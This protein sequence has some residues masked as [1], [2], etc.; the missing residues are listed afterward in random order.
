MLILCGFVALSALGC[1]DIDP[2]N[3]PIPNNDP[4]DPLDAGTPAASDPCKGAQICRLDESP[5]K[6]GTRVPFKTN[7]DFLMVRKGG[8]WRSIFI[9]G[10]NLGVGVPGT[11]AGHLAATREQYA[12]W[13][14][15][16]TKNG[17]NALRIYTL[18]Y[19]RF[20][21]ELAK[22]NK[23]HADNPIYLLQ[24]IWLDEQFKGL[25]LLTEDF[26]FNIR[27][28]V[29]CTRG[30][31]HINHRYGRAYGTFET[32]VSQWILGWVIGREV[33]PEEIE[34]TNEH[35]NDRTSFA[36]KHI[37]VTDAQPS[38][39]W[40]GERVDYLIEYELEGY[41]QTRPI[42]VSS[43]PTLD[44]LDHTTEGS[45]YTSEDIQSFDMLELKPVDAPGGLFATFHAYPYY[46]DF[47]VDDPGFREHSDAEGPNSYIGYLLDLKSHYAKMP[48]FIGEVGVPSS[49]GSAHWGH[50][51]MNHGGH[52][53]V[54]QG[55]VNG[56]LFRSVYDTNGAGAAV[57]AWIDEW[58]KPTW[59]ADARGS[60]E[61][62]RPFWHNI[63]APEQNYGLIAYD[64]GEPD[65]ANPGKST[66]SSGFV[67][68]VSTV[69]D[70][71]FFH[72]R[73]NTRSALSGSDKMVVAFDTYGSKD[74]P[75]FDKELGESVLPNG[76]TTQNR[77]EFALVINGSESAE[78]MV[79]FAYDSKRIWHGSPIEGQVYHS[80][81]TDGAPWNLVTW[82]NSQAH[83]SNDKEFWF[84]ETF[85][86][87][88]KLKIRRAGDPATSH[89]AVVIYDDHIDIR[90]PWT[91]LSVTDPS[92]LEVLHSS[93]NAA[94][95]GRNSR[96]I[97]RGIA[98]GVTYN[99]Q[100]LVETDRY[101]WDT[102]GENENIYD[103]P[104]F[105]FDEEVG[106]DWMKYERIKP[107][108][109]IFKEALDALP[110]WVD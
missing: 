105:E 23:K 30:N 99:G 100:L 78:L 42:S 79:T 59:I 90:I 27:E 45:I 10:V 71:Q 58:W 33:N 44:P 41:G 93:P 107:T 25:D 20:Y 28:M 94:R 74:S 57:F 95:K 106:P 22:H 3:P 6:S 50:K 98:I 85:H 49:W 29:D 51:D 36:G 73:L 16:M 14:D 70:T 17:V 43:W 12:H 54:E 83:G 34:R 67:T 1:E 87:I 110:D 82:M 7:E 76:V 26:D 88:G 84:E 61:E 38:E 48:L 75:Q 2:Q 40:W 15:L 65:W 37:S 5:E 77:N 31:C 11:R 89:D 46:P 24:G 4:G 72:V 104:G 63:C 60:G 39:V 66:E 91:L 92:R 62:R 13:F 64:L 56:R 101:I 97:T 35:L 68:R 47:I 108:M 18:H 80:T 9:K 53:E 81:Q 103:I 55:K 69:A 109:Q 21:E 32:D 96:A 8:N 52:T 19:P 102:W 86:E